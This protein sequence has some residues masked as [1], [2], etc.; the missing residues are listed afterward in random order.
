MGDEKAPLWK[1]I[2][3]TLRADITEGLLKPGEK[4]GSESQFVIKFAVSRAT[5]RQALLNLEREGLVRIEQGRGTFVHEN[6]IR[7]AI[8]PRTRYSQNLFNQGRSP[9]KKRIA[10]GIIP[11]SPRVAAALQVPE[12]CDIVRVH[13]INFADDTVIGAVVG[14]VPSERFPNLL[15]VRRRLND[16]TKVYAF[17]GIDDFHREVTYITAR[18]PSKEEARLLHQRRSVPI[19][20]T[21]KIDVDDQNVPIGYSENIWS[22]ERVELM[23]PRFLDTQAKG[24]SE[25]PSSEKVPKGP[26]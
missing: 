5:V 18:L 3:E 25:K 10:E 8:S 12:G 1:Q 23:V 15:E 2:F 21:R 20:E 24:A 13:Q 26:A 16:L 9:R 7:Y 14:F 22:A 4:L 17:Y 19:I 6:I 11:A